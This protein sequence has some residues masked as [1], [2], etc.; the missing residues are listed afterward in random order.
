MPLVPQADPLTGRPSLPLKYTMRAPDSTPVAR[1]VWTT[2]GRLRRGRTGARPSVR[3]ERVRSDNDRV[4]GEFERL[5]SEPRLLV[6]V[7]AEAWSW[8]A[9]S[10]LV[11]KVAEDLVDVAREM[12]GPQF[13]VVDKLGRR[14][15]E[16]LAHEVGILLVAAHD[17]D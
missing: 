14:G 13:V 6:V 8:K 16:D 10:E 1:L 12:D 17:A 9:G 7:V 3:S 4:S 2:R 15:D 5:A 11:K